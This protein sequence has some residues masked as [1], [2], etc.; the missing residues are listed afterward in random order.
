MNT[1]PRLATGS[2]GS[3]LASSWRPFARWLSEQGIDSISD[4]DADVLTAY[5]EHVAQQ[6]SSAQSKNMRMW[7][8]WRMWR[9]APYL[10]AGDRLM[11]PPWEAAAADPDDIDRWDSR[12][13]WRG[14]NR[15]HPIQSDTIAGLFVA[16]MH[17]VDDFSSD[18]LA[19]THRR[20]EMQDAVRQLRAR[21]NR[22][23]PMH[24]VPAIPR[25]LDVE[26]HLFARALMRDGD[27]D[28]WRRYLDGLKRDGKPLP[29]CT[30]RGGR[31]GLANQYLAAT[32][33]VGLGIMRNHQPSDI[34]VRVGAPLDVD[35]TGRIN[36]APWVD[37]IDFYEVDTWMRRLATAC[38]VVI[39]YLSGMRPE[40]VLALKRGC[41]RQADETD[42]LSGYEIDQAYELHG[43]TFKVR[44]HDG[45]T[46]RGG[47]E[48]RNPWHTIG[49]VAKAIN[50]MEQLHNHDLLFCVAAF[51]TDRRRSTTR[52]THTDSVIDNIRDLIEWCNSGAIPGLPVIPPDPNGPIT[53]RRFRRTLAW[54]IYRLPLGQIALG[55]QYGHIDLLQ[56]EGYGRRAHS[57]LSDVQ[58]ELAFAIRD[59]LEE[60]YE[61]LAAG[62]GV[63]GP[64]AERF[65]AAVTGYKAQFAG[66]VLTRRDA[67]KLLRNPNLVYNN[68]DMHLA[69][70]Y[71]ESLALCHPDRDRPAGI[72]RSP[73][74]LRCDPRC[75]NIARSDT[76]MA[77]LT[78]EVRDLEAEIAS[79]MTPTPI[80]VRLTQRRD[81]LLGIKA[82]HEDKHLTVAPE[83]PASEV[84]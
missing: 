47:V 28:R 78:A 60:G 4:A 37:A 7:G 80:Q 6:P 3:F 9:Y 58:E 61:E 13:A 83:V 84:L 19:A 48:R 66:S 40:E 18:I 1:P 50:V 55:L 21:A 70:C 16:C 29:G 23:Q 57:G 77:A 30:L 41:C 25:H 15:T 79:P 14:E 42:E 32:L 39:A 51:G 56:S 67:D 52:S 68:A 43:R 22:R 64:A 76:H 53:M 26:S 38:V 5:R 11:Q 36:G 27:L 20:A 69:C 63:S 44:D 35:I 45:N 33:G 82:A 75:A 24:N 31:T 54:H 12:P 46:V 17:L 73:D 74:L 62:G 34:E 59:C 81:R 2:I 49:P 10:P 65:V 71:K 8:M 72:E